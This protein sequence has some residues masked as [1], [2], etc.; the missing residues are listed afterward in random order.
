MSLM[1]RPRLGMAAWLLT[2]P[3]FVLLA[4]TLTLVIDAAIGAFEWQITTPS[5]LYGAAAAVA[6]ALGELVEWRAHWQRFWLRVCYPLAFLALGVVIGSVR[7]P[8]IAVFAL[9]VPVT[10][11]FVATCQPGRTTKPSSDAEPGVA[12]RDTTPG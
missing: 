6:I 3:V 5:A 2:P 4:T 1:R 9:T 7:W 12:E 8:S 10:A 11:L